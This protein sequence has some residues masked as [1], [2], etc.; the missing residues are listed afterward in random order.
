MKATGFDLRMDEGGFRI[1]TYLDD[2][3]RLRL[4]VHGSDRFR[5]DADEAQHHKQ[6]RNAVCLDKEH[7]HDCYRF[8]SQTGSRAP[9]RAD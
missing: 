3:S 9:C 5:A 7:E 4:D 1:E 2:Y 6:K 8:V